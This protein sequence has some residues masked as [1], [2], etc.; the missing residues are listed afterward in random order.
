M[1]GLRVQVAGRRCRP[2]MGGCFVED[3]A[4]MSQDQG[5]GT[6]EQDHS[7]AHILD[8]CMERI[9]E[10][11]ARPLVRLQ[12][13]LQDGRIAVE[14]FDRMREG[15][16]PLYDF[17]CGDM[18]GTVEWIAQMAPKTWITKEHLEVFA[19]LMLKELGGASNG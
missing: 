2:H 11:R 19:R 7:S 14:V 17:Y 1:S 16:I 6:E 13:H 15:D 4:A 10:R 18:R 5:L 3:E 9:A 12:E 8:A